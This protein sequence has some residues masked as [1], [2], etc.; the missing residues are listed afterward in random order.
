M[1]AYSVSLVV[2]VVVFAF[3]SETHTNRKRNSR[4]LFTFLSVSKYEPVLVKVAAFSFHSVV[5]YLNKNGLYQR[6]YLF[7]FCSGSL[8]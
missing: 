1:F 4:R 8:N 6:K 3:R 2:Q 5:E 7:I